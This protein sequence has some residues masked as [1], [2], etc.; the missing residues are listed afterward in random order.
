MAVVVRVALLV[1]Q[2]VLLV[3]WLALEPELQAVED[4]FEANSGSNE[5]ISHVQAVI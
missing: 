5:C 3:G 2:V 4:E 1:L